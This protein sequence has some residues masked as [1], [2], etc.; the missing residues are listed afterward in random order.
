M[1]SR[2]HAL[3]LLTLFSQ[4]SNGIRFNCFYSKTPTKYQCNLMNVIYVN[5]NDSFEIFGS[6]LDGFNDDSVSH[7]SF[8]TSIIYYLPL[9]KILHKFK[10]LTTF[11]GINVALKTIEKPLTNCDNLEVI[12]FGQNNI[13]Q[14]NAVFD[15]CK[16]LK[17]LA[18]NENKITAIAPDAFGQLYFLEEINLERH[19]LQELPKD[20]FK[21]NSNILV[22]LLG[23]GNLKKISPDDF[24]SF[25]NV[26][27]K[28]NLTAN[29]LISLGKSFEGMGNLETLS[30]S[31]N[32]INDIK[33]SDF[34]GLSSLKDL[35]L[36]S[37][38]LTKLP[39]NC[40]M[41][42]KNLQTLRLELNHIKEIPQN[43]FRSLVSL[44]SLYVFGNHLKSLHPKTFETT[45]NLNKLILRSNYFQ[46]FDS[47]LFSNLTKLTNLQLHHNQIKEYYP[48]TFSNLQELQ[49]LTSAYNQLSAIKVSS[50]G[51]LP[52]LEEFNINNNQIKHFSSTIFESFPKLRKITLLHNVC[53]DKNFNNFIESDIEYFKKCFGEILECDV[54]T[55]NQIHAC[56]IRNV[57]IDFDTD[58]NVIEG[59]IS[60]KLI[61]F[62][63]AKNSVIKIIPEIIFREF[64]ELEKL[65]LRNVG[66]KEIRKLDNCSALKF[67][68]LNDNLI[69]TLPDK[70]FENCNNLLEIYLDGNIIKEFHENALAN[71]KLLKILS[72][73]NFKVSLNKK[74][75]SE[76]FLFPETFQDLSSLIHLK[77]SFEKSLNI[78]ESLEL[79][80]NL[81]TLSLE[82]VANI[83]S[84]SLISVQSLDELSLTHSK[85]FK[86]QDETFKAP[87]SL[88][89]LDLSNND[90]KSIP[91]PLIASSMDLV[92][93]KFN[94]NKIYEIPKELNLFLKL[95]EL[96]LEL[97]EFRTLNQQINLPKLTTLK[98]SNNQIRSVSPIFFETLNNLKNLFMKGNICVSK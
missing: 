2:I 71:L 4:R 85:D 91:V 5:E 32:K 9:G 61:T 17:V 24:K 45:T 72:I 36:D 69:E 53:V 28:I 7:F 15:S 68:N 74:A 29:A 89:S 33:E 62:V 78:N 94:N 47:S 21:S 55:I 20:V 58:I 11:E 38:Q 79:S 30:L 66:L 93:L 43:V 92:I 40:F 57:T 67:M 3:L 41:N 27:K 8:I 16:K 98:L 95:R 84:E 75:Q 1:F 97:N 14:I 35:R 82:N 87:E 77:L 34:Y 25:K 83:T 59:Q 90:L 64:K 50:F 46:Y 96:H 18:L 22:L 48:G 52:K 51:V 49:L 39:E 37:N 73:K 88:I 42:L 60:G 56:E 63:Y 76:I 86:F 80:S 19:K 12:A 81:Q 54:V 13:F 70:A 31:L 65:E 26:V 44:E 23:F 6:H 10:K